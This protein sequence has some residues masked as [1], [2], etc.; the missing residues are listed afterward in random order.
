M[1]FSPAAAGDVQGTVWEIA[2]LGGAPRRV[3][4]SV[5]GGD[6]GSNERVACFR[7][8]GKSIELVTRLDRQRRSARDR[9]LRRAV[10]L[11]AS[12]VVA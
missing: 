7:L 6:L 9:A 3:I 2:A 4:D 5:G 1:Y 11:Q 12:A 8:A 10:V